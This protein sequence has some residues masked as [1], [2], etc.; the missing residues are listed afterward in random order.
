MISPKYNSIVGFGC[1]FV[2]GANI[3]ESKNGEFSG[4]KYRATKLLADR[5]NTI[6]ISHAHAGASNDRILYS[7]YEHYLNNKSANDLYIIGLSGISRQ[8][9]YSNYSKRFWDIHVYDFQDEELNRQRCKKLYGTDEHYKIYSGWRELNAKYMFNLEIEKKKLKH[10]ILSLH[11]FLKEK[12]KNYIIFNSLDNS[13]SDI[14]QEINYLSFNIDET[15]E[16]KFNKSDFVQEYSIEDCWYHYLRIEHNKLFGNFD[17]EDRSPYPPY[18]KWF[19]GG[20]PSPHAN[21]VLAD[22]IIEKHNKLYPELAL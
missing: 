6:E 19:C 1:S 20:H 22:K 16:Q 10:K 4:S 9:L 5:F 11:S 7:V 8:L 15:S 14:T 12:N 21:E 3:L 18:G 13:I 2:H 17:Q